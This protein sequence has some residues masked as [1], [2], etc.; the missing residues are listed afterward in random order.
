MTNFIG[1]FAGLALIALVVGAGYQ[2]IAGEPASTPVLLLLTLVAFGVTGLLVR[3]GL[4]RIRS[5][6]GTLRWLYPYESW[7][8]DGTAA[9]ARRRAVLASPV[10]ETQFERD[11]ARRRA[12][13]SFVAAI[14]VW[15]M[16]LP[17]SAVLAPVLAVATV[18][19][20]NLYLR[21]RDAR[22]DARDRS[23]PRDDASP[24]REV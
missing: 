18:V 9:A 8:G 4:W 5:L 15:F 1:R 6:R 2:A 24:R 3:H 14:F 19:G 7:T 16:I 22:Q 21:R 12:L 10:D 11:R 23:E 17:T 20:M 13:W